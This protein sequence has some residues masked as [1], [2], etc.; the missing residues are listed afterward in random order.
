M[1]VGSGIMH[2]LSVLIHCLIW[3]ALEARGMYLGGLSLRHPPPFRPSDALNFSV[4]LVVIVL[5]FKLI[6]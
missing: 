2:R 6:F 4:A 3:N 5:N 1:A